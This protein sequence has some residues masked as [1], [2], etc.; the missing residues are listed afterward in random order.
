M[1]ITRTNT[2]T[3]REQIDRAWEKKF[4]FLYRSGIGRKYLMILGMARSISELQTLHEALPANERLN[5]DDYIKLQEFW[6][7]FF[8]FDIDQPRPKDVIDWLI[9][10]INCDFYSIGTNGFV[11]YYMRMLQQRKHPYSENTR[12]YLES[13]CSIYAR[14]ECPW[15][16]IPTL[17]VIR[18]FDHR[19]VVFMSYYDL[20][21]SILVDVVVRTSTLT[22]DLTHQLTTLPKYCYGQMYLSVNDGYSIYLGYVI[23]AGTLQKEMCKVNKTREEKM[24]ITSQQFLTILTNLLKEAGLPIQGEVTLEQEGKPVE[25]GPET[26]GA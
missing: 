23:N 21:S 12:H 15:D 1:A 20:S 2:R 5:R 17:F 25:F 11:E 24:V 10:E 6:E 16:D 19:F 18:M 3:L 9:E 8:R 13:R 4:R 7:E 14:D 22:E 26:A